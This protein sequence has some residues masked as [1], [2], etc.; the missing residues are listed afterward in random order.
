MVSANEEKLV[1]AYKYPFS[2]EAKELISEMNAKF[3][4]KALSDGG[5]RVKKALEN[6]LPF[7]EM[8]MTS[9]MQTQL[10]SYVYARMIASAMRN[11][12]VLDSYATAEAQR[13]SGALRLGTDGELIRLSQELGVEL[14]KERE[15][16]CTS[17]ES[18]LAGM[19]RLE[20]FALSRQMLKEGKVYLS[21]DSLVSILRERIKKEVLKGL[22][23]PIKELPQ[24][25]VASSR[26]IAPPAAERAAGSRDKDGGVRYRWIEQL[27]EHPIPDVRHRTVN[28]ILA[29]YLTTIRGLSEE[30]AVKIIHDYIERCK[31]INPDTKVNLTYIKYQCHYSKT[32]GLKPLSQVRARELLGEHV[33]FDN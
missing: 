17:F 21:R 14:K 33:P 26:L 23:I 22:P 8:K 9:L 11:F 7:D 6:N 12:S 20:S 10:I 32:K 5:L 24:E 27:I 13:A 16:F 4:R 2:K 25:V 30:E 18:Y 29:P 1:F 15:Q 19:P 3:D 31:L 28:L